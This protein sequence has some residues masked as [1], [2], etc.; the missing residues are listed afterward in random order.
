MTM[1]QPLLLQIEWGNKQCFSLGS[2]IDHGLHNL[3][4]KGLTKMKE[5]KTKAHDVFE[6]GPP[7]NEYLISWLDT[8]AAGRTLQLPV[9]IHS[10]PIGVEA[11]YLRAGNTE[12][13]ID[14]DTT[15]MSLD[16]PMHL[17]PYCNSYPCRVWIEGTWG[18][19]ISDGSQEFIP[20]FAVRKVVGAAG[21]QE[22]KIRILKKINAY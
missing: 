2:D 4:Y 15:A 6:L 14:L 5:K 21:V 13:E 16:L 1:S 19:L 22:T 7:I 18:A 17:K 12:I 10:G 8:E 3:Q 11:A 20:I 9:D